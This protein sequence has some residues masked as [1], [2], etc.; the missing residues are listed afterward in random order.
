[1]TGRD[2]ARGV[3]AAAGL[4]CALAGW[5]A[6]D[7]VLAGGVRADSPEG[8]RFFLFWVVPLAL[9]ALF[10][11]WLAVRGAAPEARRVATMGCLGGLLL[12]C[13]TFALLMVP[14]VWSG[15]A[16]GG[17]VFASRYAPLAGALG[18]VGGIAVARMRKRR[19]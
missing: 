1:V 14:R 13:V 16:L 10:L 19:R 5:I 7:S 15:D 4:G 2:T 8:L 9:V 18:L 11:G 17:A 12:G 3:R 6:I